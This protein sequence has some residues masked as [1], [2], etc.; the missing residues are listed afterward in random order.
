MLVAVATICTSASLGLPCS[1]HQ[2]RT[3]LDLAPEGLRLLPY[4]ASWAGTF[5][6][7]LLKQRTG[8]TKLHKAPKGLQLL[9]YAT[10]HAACHD[11]CHAACHMLLAMLL[12]ICCLPCCL[13]CC[14]PHAACHAACHMLIAICCFLGQHIWL[15]RLKRRTR[16]ASLSGI[17]GRCGYEAWR[18][19]ARY[20]TCGPTCMGPWGAAAD[21]CTDVII[22]YLSSM[23]SPLAFCTLPNSMQ[24]LIASVLLH[25]PM[26]VCLCVC[27][28][29]QL[30]HRGWRPATAATCH[31]QP[32]HADAPYSLWWQRK[33]R[34]WSCCWGCWGRGC[35]SSGRSSRGGCRWSSSRLRLEPGVPRPPCCGALYTTHRTTRRGLLLLARGRLLLN[36]C[37][38]I[39]A[40]GHLSLQLLLLRLLLLLLLPGQFALCIR[41]GLACG[42]LGGHRCELSVEFPGALNYAPPS[43]LPGMISMPLTQS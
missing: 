21:V 43:L 38:S 17:G 24:S 1:E 20:R 6:L 26:C 42:P 14:M 27:M 23:N 16:P 25:L 29:V 19:A 30:P 32:C 37:C 2:P 13:P 40:G 8:H 35:W 34:C 9:P 33:R 41:L 5:G 7:W 12:S 18:G 15:W 10:C 4:A 28:R 22:L 11:T 36:G 31:R 3:N 39:R